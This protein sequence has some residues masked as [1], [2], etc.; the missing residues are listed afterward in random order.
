MKLANSWAEEAPTTTSSGQLY[1]E[2]E[3][4]DE[5]DE[6]EDGC[7]G[8]GWWKYVLNKSGTSHKILHELARDVRG[9]EQRRG[10]RLTVTQYKTICD[11]WADASRPYLRQGVDYF[12]RF[13]AKL[14]TVTMP[15]G[16]TLGSAF[17]RAKR[18][19]PPSKVM[20]LSKELQ[21]L[22]SLCRELQEMAGDQPIMLCQTHVAKLFSVSQQTISDWIRA[23]RTLTVLRL[24]EPAVK[25]VRAARYYFVDEAP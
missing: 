1:D 15:K 5:L 11:K 25:N 17:Q 6:S 24:A 14:S 12:A 9:V 21:L 4:Y 8:V 22:A 7:G 20:L 19:Q 2:Y 13:L 3:E 10:K 16:Q 23:L 18:K